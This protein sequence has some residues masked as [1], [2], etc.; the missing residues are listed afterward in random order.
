MHSMSKLTTFIAGAGLGAAVTY[1]LDPRSGGERRGV[2]RDKAGQ[3]AGSGPVQTVAHTA[4]S[5]AQSVAHTA[6]SQAQGVAAKAKSVA[7]GGDSAPGDD[8]TLKDKVESEIFRPADAPKGS[9]LVSV[10][11]GIV[12]LRGECDTEWSERLESEAG[13]VT[14]VRGVRNLTHR[15]GETPPNIAGTPGVAGS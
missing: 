5:Q 10:A 6:A 11:N 3:V 8:N 9:I 4:A 14:G 12:E 2:A 7:T 15:P 1:F 13:K